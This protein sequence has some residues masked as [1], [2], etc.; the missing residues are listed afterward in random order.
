[1]KDILLKGLNASKA[2]VEELNA[3]IE[4]GDD[5]KIEE[6]AVATN[7]MESFQAK[8]N[9]LEEA[10]TAEEEAKAQETEE[11]IDEA[12]KALEEGE[13]EEEAQEEEEEEIETPSADDVQENSKAMY[14]KGL[15][16]SIRGNNLIK[17]SIRKEISQDPKVVDRAINTYLTGAKERISAHLEKNGVSI[18]E[19]AG[20]KLIN[21]STIMEII[22]A[23]RCVSDAFLGRVLTQNIIQGGQ[24]KDSKSWDITIWD[25]HQLL[26]DWTCEAFDCVNEADH[27]D[28]PCV[29][30]SNKVRILYQCLYGSCYV[31]KMA[32]C[33]STQSLVTMSLE[34]LAQNMFDTVLF[35]ML[36][37]DC[38]VTENINAYDAPDAFAVDWD[39]KR[40]A[41][42][43]NHY[44]RYA[45]KKVNGVK[46]EIEYKVIEV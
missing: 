15:T 21:D 4:A 11:A 14:A 36:R 37:D 27:F 31:N 33:L 13:E 2:K 43:A 24:F 3:L 29:H 35:K 30:A 38:S 32:Q 39:A 12:N 40:L 19:G 1:M 23:D 20:K 46:S 25:G 41:D 45:I 6:L 22:M 7:S 34:T 8:L 44:L 26:V 16:K 17:N 9:E 18:K 28:A 42:K 5:S 10:E